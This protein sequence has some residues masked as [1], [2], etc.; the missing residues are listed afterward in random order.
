[1]SSRN[2]TRRHIPEEGVFTFL[3]VGWWSR[4]TWWF[5]LYEG[6]L[7][8][9]PRSVRSLT[10]GSGCTHIMTTFCRKMAQRYVHVERDSIEGAK[11]R[12]PKMS[13]SEDTKAQSYSQ[14]NCSRWQRCMRCAGRWSLT[15]A[16]KKVSTFALE[17]SSSSANGRSPKIST[18]GLCI[19]F[20]CVSGNH[21]YQHSIQQYP[22]T[23]PPQTRCCPYGRLITL[24]VIYKQCSMYP[25]A[26]KKKCLEC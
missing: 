19:Q 11:T 8:P 6:N 3:T 5:M 21:T 26:V 15:V 13:R 2:D 25:I 24:P 14:S 17:V 1:M 18:R 20:S 23:L 22:P 7:G 10:V 9:Q 12:F 4:G 16:R